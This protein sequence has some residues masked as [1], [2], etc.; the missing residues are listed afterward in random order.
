MP[1][2]KSKAL[3][4]PRTECG[5]CSATFTQSDEKLLCTVCKVSL[6]RYCAGVPLSHYPPLSTSNAFVCLV[7]T[8][9]VNELARKELRAE[10]DS[11]KTEVQV[12]RQALKDFQDR[13]QSE[14]KPFINELAELRASVQK[15]NDQSISR[16]Q[17]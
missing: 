11:L 6:H 13:Q 4:A 2:K 17:Q 16:V 7:C 12:L 8:N 3:N 9:K 14:I 1:P 15:S 10:I 5:G